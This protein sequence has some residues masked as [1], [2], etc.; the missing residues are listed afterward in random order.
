MNESRRKR[1]GTDREDWFKLPQAAALN[2]ING[3]VIKTIDSEQR[4]HAGPL[5][6]GHT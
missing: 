2:N 3:V 6:S 5:S 1:R 4:K